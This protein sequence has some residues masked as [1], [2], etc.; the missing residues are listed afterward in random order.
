MI[1]RLIQWYYDLY[2]SHY[3]GCYQYIQAMPDA[4]P[5]LDRLASALDLDDPTPAWH[6]VATVVRWEI[7]EGRLPIGTELPPIRSIAR[8]VGLH[9]HTVRRAWGA[10]AEEGILTQRQGRGA[11]IVRAAG[12]GGGWIPTSPSAGGEARPRVWVV[13][14]ALERAA[15]LAVRLAARWRV[16]AVPYPADAAPPPPGAILQLAAARFD[17]SRWPAREADITR[18]DPVL[19]PITVTL[20]R[21]NARLLACESV[22]IVSGP[23]DPSQP[24]QLLLRQLP[25]L[26]LRTRRQDA[27]AGLGE[28]G[29]CLWLHMPAAWQLLD[30]EQRSRP[31]VMAIEFDW[32]PGPLAGVAKRLGWEGRER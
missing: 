19:D 11:R 26:G 8:A 16:T 29:A 9:Y 10:L 6:Q 14:V 5:L 15:R 7:A 28:L 1:G 17:E 13:D 22:V 12:V 18:I 25:R 23:G 20:T 3:T 4:V 27:S 2:H 32:A 30:W 24:V 21:R 31:D